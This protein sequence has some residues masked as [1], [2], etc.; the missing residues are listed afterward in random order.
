MIA[1]KC[2][3]NPTFQPYASGGD[4][5]D[6]QLCSSSISVLHYHCPCFASPER[7]NEN[8]GDQ[9]GY[10]GWDPTLSSVIVAHQGTKPTSM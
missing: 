10:V 1:A 2:S 6:T 3:G 5:T 8:D 7:T 9:S 4:G